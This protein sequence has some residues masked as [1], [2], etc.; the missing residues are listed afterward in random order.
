MKVFQKV[1]EIVAAVVLLSVLGFMAAYCIVTPDP[2]YDKG[3]AITVQQQALRQRMLDGQE[4]QEILLPRSISKPD[5]NKEPWHKE[6]QPEM[7]RQTRIAEYPAPPA[8]KDGQRQT[9]E[10]RHREVNDPLIEK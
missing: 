7:K 5:T 10:F 6:T 3:G 8:K 4:P 1:I 2:A 9:C